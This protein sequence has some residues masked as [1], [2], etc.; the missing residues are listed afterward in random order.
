MATSRIHEEVSAGAA[1][2]K[3]K[4]GASTNVARVDKQASDQTKHLLVASVLDWLA[5]DSPPL[6][7]RECLLEPATGDRLHERRDAPVHVRERSPRDD[8][9]R[10]PRLQL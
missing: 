10:E 1:V 6:G 7:A 8:H 4:M 3:G 9:V 2:T 5:R